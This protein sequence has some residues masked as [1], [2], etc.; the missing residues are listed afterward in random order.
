MKQPIYILC[1]L[2][3]SCTSIKLKKEEF[4][5]E[6]DF[7]R[8]NFSN[9]FK[10]H[11]KA[12]DKFE[13]DSV[14]IIY[15][16]INDRFALK[17]KKNSKIVRT[18]YTYLVFLN[19]HY[20][21]AQKK[22]L[23]GI[24]DTKGNI[25][26]P[27]NYDAIDFYNID[28]PFFLIKKNGKQA[29]FDC[30]GKEIYPFTINFIKS[31]VTYKNK[32]FLIT[33]E[34]NYIE[35]MLKISNGKV[36]IIQYVYSFDKLKNNLAKVYYIKNSTALYGVYNME[37]DEFI[38][39]YAL[40]Y[41]NKSKNEIWAMS[42]KSDHLSYDTVID[43]N[44]TIKPNKY[45][46]VTKIENDNIFIETKNGM[47]IMDLNG[48]MAPFSYPKIESFN[49]DTDQYSFIYGKEF[50]DYQKRIFKF[51]TS[52]DSKKYGVID[53]EGNIIV[54][55]E[56]FDYI[57]YSDLNDKNSY[58]RN[59]P[60]LKQKYLRDNKLDRLFYASNYYSN[61]SGQVKIFKDNGEELITI[62]NEKGDYCYLELS[63]FSTHGHLM[64]KCNDKMKI[65]DLKSKKIVFEVKEPKSFENF[66]ER[67]INGYYYF[68]YDEPMHTKINYL[69]NKLKLLYQQE[70]VNDSVWYKMIGGDKV[71][72][73]NNT[74]IGLINFDEKEIVPAEYDK[75]EIL[76][77]TFNIVTL[78][79]KKGVITDNNKIV[80]EII[81]DKIIYNIN[82]QSFDCYLNDKKEIKYINQ[83]KQN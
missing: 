3:L 4:I 53:I 46:N 73:K 24:I 68:S 13:T 44:F 75:I 38:N 6:K 71:Y 36:E 30:N 76:N 8:N 2:I 39:D 11:E 28:N 59:L 54:N 65:Y 52:K 67:S 82:N 12:K 35:Q 81:Y 66:K 34:D 61:K 79:E 51:Y 83:I 45:E 21:I 57:I 26:I 77:N 31:E 27:C 32:V 63:Q 80:I 78:G 70:V 43:S 29:V 22:S 64:A 74:K 55:A 56:K 48:N 41:Y 23:F 19:E 62:P 42:R 69:S 40:C 7:R 49:K 50:S 72:F 1:F 15:D 37:N 47:Q 10:Q 58:N 60:L 33:K 5:S 25:I 20:L 9:Y 16:V 18:E 17:N 14:E